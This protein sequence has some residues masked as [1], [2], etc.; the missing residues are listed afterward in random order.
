LE[1]RELLAEIARDDADP[2]RRARSRPAARALRAAALGRTRGGRRHPDV[3]DAPGYEIGRGLP[4]TLQPGSCQLVSVQGSVF[5]VQGS[6]FGYWFD[7]RP[8][9]EPKP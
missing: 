4:Y 1:E 5:K 6:T 2:H 3:C 8:E 7:A 9:P